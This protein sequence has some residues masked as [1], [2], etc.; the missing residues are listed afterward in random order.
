V[1]YYIFAHASLVLFSSPAL[2]TPVVHFT[3][4][5]AAYSCLF[6]RLGISKLSPT[7]LFLLIEELLADSDHLT[8]QYLNLS[9]LLLML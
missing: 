7:I 5:I 3:H 1:F 8:T 2:A 9:S 4:H 6:L